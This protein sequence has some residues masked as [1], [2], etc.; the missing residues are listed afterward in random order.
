M[1]DFKCI[2]EK[3][4]KKKKTWCYRWSHLTNALPSKKKFFYTNKINIYSAICDAQ[5][6]FMI[7]RA[8]NRSTHFRLTQWL[9]IT[10][11][12]TLFPNANTLTDTEEI[13]H[14]ALLLVKPPERHVPLWETDLECLLRESPSAHE[15]SCYAGEHLPRVAAGDDE[16]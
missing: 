4:Y 6:I 5:L 10:Y 9:K 13:I 3:S 7:N 11:S 8:W 14:N 12:D 2:Q 1:L 15:D 16:T